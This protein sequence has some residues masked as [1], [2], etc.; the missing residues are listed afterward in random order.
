VVEHPLGKGEVHSSIL[1]GSTS[2]SSAD[3][4]RSAPTLPAGLDLRPRPRTLRDPFWFLAQRGAAGGDPL[5]DIR[6][7]QDKQCFA[8]IMKGGV[9]YMPCEGARHV[10]RVY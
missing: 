2:L 10:R 4:R 6:V 1:C 9:R 3:N 5:K 8:F 7:L